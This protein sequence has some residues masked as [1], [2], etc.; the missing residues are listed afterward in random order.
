MI[1]SCR[2]HSADI[3]GIDW[4]PMQKDY[5]NQPM[6]ILHFT[7]SGTMIK[8]TLGTDV[9]STI[10]YKIVDN[11]LYFD[12]DESEHAIIIKRSK[13]SLELQITPELISNY[14][15]FPKYANKDFSDGLRK[16]LLNNSWYLST[17]NFENESLIEF[18]DSLE[19]R[20][21]RPPFRD[22][23]KS[24]GIHFILNNYS[25]RQT[26]GYWGLDYYNETNILAISE[27]YGGINDII[28]VTEMSDTLIHGIQYQDG[29]SVSV[30]LIKREPLLDIASILSSTEW[31][32]ADFKEVPSNTY[33][34]GGKDSPDECYF[35]LADLK[36]N[37]KALSFRED[38]TFS[39]R[40]K[41]DT[42][43]A[44]F[45]RIIDSSNI[46]ELTNNYMKCC[47]YVICTSYMSI[48][49]Y[50]SDTLTIY[51]SEEIVNDDQVETIYISEVYTRKNQ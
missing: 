5:G 27:T 11:R 38:F 35:T 19:D 41:N 49:S 33:R 45:W 4:F 21:V 22:K 44:G 24:A 10:P 7:D 23:V 30:K 13:R 50:D 1:T 12:N 9:E 48:L 39:I 42:I 51:N 47:D 15:P 18:K 2:N 43:R 34:L 46:I 14:I 37:S 31:Q 36:T 26:D 25:N 40:N 3:T 16:L 29:K 32:L 20:I 28:L 17:S 6:S 8:R